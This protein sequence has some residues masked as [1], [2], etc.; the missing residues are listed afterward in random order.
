MK[1]DRREFIVLGSVGATGLFD[2]FGISGLKAGA[3]DRSP[4]QQPAAG[5]P[6][7][8]APK[9]EDVRRN[10]GIFTMRGGTIGWLVNRDA[11]VVVDTQYP[12]TAGACLD[13]L[14]QKAANRGIDTLFNTHHHGDHTGGNG[15]FR[16]AAKRIVAH[17]NVP[18]LMRKAA[19]AANPPA[20]APTVP[21]ATFDKTWSEDFGDEKIT[22]RY[23]GPGHT[24]GD[25]MIHF[26]RAHVVH[27]GDLLFHERHPRVDRPAGASIQ[28]WMKILERTAKA[29]P[30]DTIYIAGHARDGAP[31]T[32]D[33]AA[34]LRFR[35]YFDAVLAFTRKGIAAGQ[36]KE[37]IA[38]TTTLPGFES[39]QG[40]GTVL[41]L[42]GVLTA[43]YE[44][45]SAR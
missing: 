18:D 43:A 5:Q 4:A 44:E 10:V 36:T 26:E 20:A 9:F 40:S 24:G 45:L 30:A 35:D 37:A 31:V 1:L 15:V 38:A 17:K 3:A 6:P 41:T 8:A 29:M 34:V 16:P 42:G 21:D 33:R 14:K 22:A 39:Y 12:D 19:A 13:G 25:A 23:D 11:L 2:R 28:N 27:M 32:V 7:P